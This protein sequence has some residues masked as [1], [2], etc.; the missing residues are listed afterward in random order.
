[1]KGLDGNEYLL[2]GLEECGWGEGGGLEN[3]LCKVSRG[4]LYSGL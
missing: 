3:M 2:T 4:P 1:M